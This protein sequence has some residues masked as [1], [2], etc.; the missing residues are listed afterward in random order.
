MNS[1]G[2][3]LHSIPEGGSVGIPVWSPDGH[4]LAFV[5]DPN[6]DDEAFIYDLYVLDIVNAELHQITHGDVEIVFAPI[7]SPDGRFL[8]ASVN[9]GGQSDLYILAADGTSIEKIT[10]DALDSG[11]ET[12]IAFYLSTMVSWQRV[13]P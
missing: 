13:S 6:P 1:D 12:P 3:E 7:W 4:Y 8:A 11:S 9:D 5:F 10:S 2:S